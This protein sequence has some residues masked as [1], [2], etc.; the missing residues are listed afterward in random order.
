VAVLLANDLSDAD[1]AAAVEDLRKVAGADLPPGLVAEVTGG[2][3]FRADIGAVFEGAD[4]TLLL[5]TAASS[6][7]SCS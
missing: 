7:R 1:N 3:A 5:A 2:P 4:V 6:R